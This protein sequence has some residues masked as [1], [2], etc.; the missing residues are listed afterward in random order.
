MQRSYRAY[1]SSI[2]S[3]VDSVQLHSLLKLLKWQK[4]VFTFLQDTTETKWANGSSRTS[5]F[6]AERKSVSKINFHK[7]E[8]TDNWIHNLHKTAHE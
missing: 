7:S 5:N 4:I 1:S 8:S 3:S 2:I 6:K